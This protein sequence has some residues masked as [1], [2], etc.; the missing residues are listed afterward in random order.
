MNSK[1]TLF[2][3][4]GLLCDETVWHGQIEG[5][6]DTV[7]PRAVTYKDARSISAMA[8]AVL[9]DAPARFAVAGHSM[10]GRVALEV[11]RQVPERVTG[12]ALLDS[13]TDG[14]KD[15]ER[16]KRMRWVEMARQDGMEALVREWLPPMVHPDRLDNESLMTPLAD[17]VRRF[18]AEQFAGQ[19]EALLTRPDA[20][21]LL[22]QIACPALVLCGRQ[23]AWRA[24]EEH[25]KMAAMIP[26][27]AFDIIEACGHM[28]PIE[29]PEDVN[30]S[31]RRWLNRI[32]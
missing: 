14:P 2:L 17:M 21:P 32:A 20:T 9:A 1:P 19:I 4:P 30:A 3:L 22:S 26:G 31:L 12:L 28:A 6:A 7:Q 27:A 5:L 16:E 11:F 23:D 15:G 13:A 29:R 18:T 24:A 25:E 10:G 8:E